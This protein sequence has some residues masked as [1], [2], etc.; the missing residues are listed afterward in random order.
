MG[1]RM[2][3][4][5]VLNLHSLLLRRNKP[6]KFPLYVIFGNNEIFPDPRL[7]RVVLGVVTWR[8]GGEP[9]TA[10]LSVPSLKARETVFFA[11]VEP[12]IASGSE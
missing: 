2:H 4:G 12:V 1:G 10:E 8:M 11:F 5:T 3:I 9:H 7:D 6:P